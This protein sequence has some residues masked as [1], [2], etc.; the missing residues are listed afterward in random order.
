MNQPA[1]SGKLQDTDLPAL[2][3]SICGARQTGLLHLNRQDASKTI[4]VQNGRIIFA[5]SNRA[6]DRL[7]ELLLR[8]G[9]L[10]IQH[11]EE[12]SVN[13]T[14]GKR[15]G[16]LLVEMG[17]LRPEEL[18][19]AVI[20]QVKEIVFDVFLWSDGT[21]NFEQGE[22]PSREVITLKLSTPEVIMGGIQRIQRWSRVLRGVGGLDATYQ[23]VGGR[24]NLLHLM[25]L[26]TEHSALLQTLE[27]PM[28]VRDLCRR[29]LL[30]DFEV[31][32][33]LWAFRVIGLIE[34]ASMAPTAGAIPQV[35]VPVAAPPQAAATPAAKPEA[36]APAAAPAQTASPQ[37]QAPPGA[38]SMTMAIP[39]LQPERDAPA[40]S[41][42]AGD[43]EPVLE[44]V[45]EEGDPAAPPQ[46]GAAPQDRPA[47][48]DECQI[49]GCLASFN[50]RHRH[51]YATLAPKA[52]D[53][54][55]EIVQRCLATM[56]KDLPGLFSGEAPD[57]EGRFNLDAL[58]TNIFAF[59]VISYATGLDMLIEREIEMAESLFGSAV[60]REI[61]QALKAVK[62]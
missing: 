17:H 39:V 20:E 21:Y 11:F 51:F 32:R 49:E 25:T 36:S 61:S 16:A 7:G 13:L 38:A 9:L 60:R 2:L 44:V 19:K 12:A 54:A 37:P 15:L 26:R 4:F 52:G 46:A 41:G 55:P 18:I 29:G 53:K 28:S 31:C 43:N 57:A 58:K 24:E 8:K 10:R 47:A 35:E 42:A 5:T 34:L 59:G 1:T 14:Q 62:K 22:L 40:E 27:L 45:E 6:D 30:A 50:E 56:E 33:A 23:A 3:A 48:L